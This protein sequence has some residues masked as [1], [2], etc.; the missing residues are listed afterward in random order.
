LNI[1]NKAI[2]LR[3]GYVFS[4]WEEVDTIM[5]AYGKQ[6]GFTIIKKRLDRYSD[7]SIKH[8]GFGCEFGG[9]YQPKKQI[10][11]YN[12]R[13]HKSKRQE[14]EWHANVNCPKNFPR[15]TLTT[16]TDIHNHTLYSDTKKLLKAK[17]PTQSILDCDLINAIQKFKVKTDVAQDAS[18][19]LQTLIR[20]KS[21]DPE[22][23]VEFQLDDENRLIRLFWMSPTQI[24][25]WLE[26]HDVILNDNT[27]KTNRYQMPLSLFLAV[28]NN[29]RSR[30]VAQALVSDET[31]ESYKWI[32]ECTKNATMTEPLVF[33]TDADPAAEAAIGQIYEAT[34]QVHCIFHISENL[35]KNLKSKL[36]N[37]YESFIYDFY[38]CHYLMRV[39]FPSRQAWARAF[40]S[41]IFTAGIQTT[42][43]VEGFNNIIKRVLAANSTLCDLAD[44][45]DA[46]LEDEAKWNQFFEYRTMSSCMGITSVGRDLFPA[47]DKVMSEY[48]TPH[49]LSAERLEMAQCLY[50]IANKM[51]NH[52]EDPG[53]SV[54]DGFIEDVYDAKQILLKSMIAEVGE[55]NV[56]EVWKIIDMRPENKH[57]HFVVVVDPISYLC[58]CMFNISRGIVCRHYFR[59]MMISTV[60]GF[61]IQMVPSRWYTDNQK[62]KDVVMEACCFANQEAVQNCSGAVL[63]PNPSTIPKTVTSI[64]RRAVQKKAKYGEVWGLARQAAQLAIEQDNYGEM[65]GWL[66]Q[67]IN[68]QKATMAIPTGSVRNRDLLEDEIHK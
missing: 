48:L 13:D 30:L 37:Q 42:S 5:E 67:F 32:L 12:H 16:L 1:P 25:L 58:S 46:R 8:R 19:L 59:V 62:D 10:D 36:Y 61:H 29:T 3:T 54:T 64:L 38:Q 68:R 4:S 6:Q 53:I 35:P 41:K 63:T 56:R 43:R 65:V 66:R 15:I 40:T 49:I 55:R 18:R 34:Y 31:T 21:H 52:N 17:F 22:W 44:A 26:Y 50:F 23:F 24:T 9:R 47:I 28:D 51:D 39:L 27:A 11:I 14:C 60:A 33:V 7:G 57:I 45:L 2:N 20:H